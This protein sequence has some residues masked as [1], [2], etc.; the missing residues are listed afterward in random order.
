MHKACRDT[1]WKLMEVTNLR[2]LLD[3]H[4]L[5]Y[6][7]PAWCGCSAVPAGRGGRLIM[8]SL[9]GQRMSLVWLL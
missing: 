2:V 3:L 7:L 4:V 1:K 6:V 9:K 8:Q 5:Y